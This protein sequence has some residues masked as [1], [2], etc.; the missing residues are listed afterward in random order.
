MT[1]FVI[2]DNDI[3]HNYELI[4]RNTSALVIPTLKA[5]CYGLGADHVFELLMHSC[6]VSSFAV[7]RLEE[8]LPL[9]GRGADILLLSCYH[10]LPSIRAAVDADLILAVDSVGQARRVAE[11]AK[12]R[13][14]TAR[15]HIKVD[16]GFGRFGFAPDGVGDI[17]SLFGIEGLRV[18][19]IFSHLYA[20]FDLKSSSADR[21]LEEFNALISALGERGLDPGIRHI[22]G[23][24]AALRD[25]KFHLDAVR[26]GS[27]LTG[28]VPMPTDLPLKRV[29]RFETEVIDIR[30]LKKGA[31]V[32]YGGVFRLKRDSRI[33]VLPAGT[34]DG[35]LMKKDYDTF[36]PRDILRYGLGVFRMFFRDNRLRVTING[37]SAPSVGRIALTH[38]MVDVTGID[39]KNGDTAV[40]D[41]SPLCVNAGVAREY[42][43]V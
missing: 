37:V 29:G 26:I 8:A 13:G 40:F 20:A 7:S 3:I 14:K 17:A 9:A 5:D 12:E 27:A 33:A 35:V 38:T 22:A 30:T 11:Y 16:T 15:I 25:K 39:C 19:G 28:R 41:I 1:R 32:G 36:R 10:D 31:N 43:N 2:N 34:A 18:R 4:A 23:S 6:G 42:E 24:S 21:Q